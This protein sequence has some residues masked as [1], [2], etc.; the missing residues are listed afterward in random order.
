MQT[1]R[2]KVC[3]LRVYIA[4]TR[5][6][7]SVYF[8]GTMCQS[9]SRANEPVSLE[10]LSEDVL[11]RIVEELTFDDKLQLQLVSKKLYTLMTH[12]PQGERVWGR[13]NLSTKFSEYLE[14]D[15]F[16]NS[17]VRR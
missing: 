14:D 2:S 3:L 15:G 17:G 1:L 9:R 5:P 13:C 11:C 7:L 12:P 4:K 8:L 16:I 10:T 6:R